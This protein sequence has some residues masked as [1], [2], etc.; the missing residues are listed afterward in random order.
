MASLPLTEWDGTWE[1]QRP[2]VVRVMGT[3]LSPMIILKANRAPRDRFT[4]ASKG[5]S[6]EAFGLALTSLNTS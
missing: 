3:P 2:L 5:L 1:G 4:T 6:V